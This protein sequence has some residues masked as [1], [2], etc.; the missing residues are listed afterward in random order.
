MAYSN[1]PEHSS[2]H[3]E[4]TNYHLL[5]CPSN[6]QKHKS[7]TALEASQKNPTTT[8]N[9]KEGI[10][11]ENPSNQ[12]VAA[13]PLLGQCEP[14]LTTCQVGPITSELGDLNQAALPLPGQ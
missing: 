8:Q 13:F 4:L 5:E 1:Q 10:H 14:K 11:P 12:P 6:H 7:S 9:T 3:A 2:K